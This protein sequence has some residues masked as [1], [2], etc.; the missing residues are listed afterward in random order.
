M[1]G[2]ARPGGC[3]HLI[4][5]DLVGQGAVDVPPHLVTGTG[6][7]PFHPI[8]VKPTLAG[9]HLAGFSAIV[10]ALG[11]IA[12]SAPGAAVQHPVRPILDKEKP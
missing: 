12:W 10:E 1:L 5:V 4:L 6:P 8:G 2:E 7:I 9:C 11:F 3:G